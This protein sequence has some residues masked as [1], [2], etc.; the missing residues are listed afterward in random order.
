MFLLTLSF[1]KLVLFHKF[2]NLFSIFCSSLA[3]TSLNVMFHML[4]V[5]VNGLCMS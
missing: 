1:H 3:F 5:T 4:I 2:F